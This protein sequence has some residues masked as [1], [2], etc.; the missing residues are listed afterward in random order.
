MS[1]QTESKISNTVPSHTQE[2]SVAKNALKMTF[3]TMTSRVLGLLREVLL[4]ALFG[5]FVTDSWMAAFRVPNLFR[6]LLGEGSLSVSFI[7]VFIDSQV[8]DA[9]GVRT[10]NLVNSTYTVLLLVLSVIMALGI[11]YP[12]ALLDLILDPSY[13]AQ[14]EKYLLTVRLAKIMFLFV[15][16]ISTF[17]FYMGIL[18]ALGEFF[19]PALAP[20]FLNVF[21]IISTLIPDHVTQAF[22]LQMGDQLAWGV[23]VGGAFQAAILIPFL[24]KRNF[25]PRFSSLS[26]TFKNADMKKV[27]MNMLPGLAGVGLLQFTTLLNLRFSSSLQEGTISYI[28]YVDRLIELPLSL[29]SVSLGTALLPSLSRLWSTNL[30]TEM[31]E[32][33]RKFLEINLLISM[34]GA[35]VLFGLASPIIDLLFGRGKFTAVD[36]AASADILKTYCWVLLFVSGVRV[37]TPAY[38]AVQNTWFPAVVSGVSLLIHFFLAPAL[39]ARFAV[40]GLMMSTITTA[41]INII[42]LLAF[43]RHFI[44]Q[45]NYTS[46]IKN[47]SKYVLVGL[48]IWAST[49]TY[50]VIP[51]DFKI[52]FFTKLISLAIVLMIAG[53]TFLVACKILKVTELDFVINRLKGRFLKKT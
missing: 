32:Q 12:Q 3:G 38:Y 46:F 25:L 53:V 42:L 33:S 4:A 47:I 23:V 5:K 10:R 14:T 1:E 36:V 26:E 19:W 41:F 20:T 39:M 15:F 6:R 29:I 52:S 17:A 35:C 44:T 7:P 18:N 34:A 8:K 21:M 50:N 22:G 16:F 40:R 49:Q 28:N 31:S 43:Y 27:F 9:S 45:F 30:K 48:L 37:L 13:I 11:F 51:Q 2:R 24:M